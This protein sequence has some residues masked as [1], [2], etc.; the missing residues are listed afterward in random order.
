VYDLFELRVLE[1][2]LMAPAKI[3]RI[4]TGLRF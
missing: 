1:M 4:R 3:G 2:R